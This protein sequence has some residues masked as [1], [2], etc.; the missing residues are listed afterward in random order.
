MVFL[1]E[2]CL[3]LVIGLE[4]VR[5]EGIV[6]ELWAWA[7]LRPQLRLKLYHSLEFPQQILRV[8]GEA[9]VVGVESEVGEEFGQM[10]DQIVAGDDGGVRDKG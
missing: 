4:E 2:K 1:A 9:N 10:G 7:G 6:S 5:D 8:D 3:L